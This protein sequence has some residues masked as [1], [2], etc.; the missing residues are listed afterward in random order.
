FR[1]IEE[2]D[3]IMARLKPYP[4]YRDSGVEWIGE[5]PKDWQLIKLRYLVTNRNNSRNQENLPYLGLENIESKTGKIISINEDIIEGQ[6]IRFENK[7]VLFGKLRPY[8]A[9]VAHVDFE[10]HCS[11]EFI[12]LKA[13]KIKAELL[14]YIML[15][16]KFISHVDSS[17]YGTKM[18]RANWEF[19]KNIFIPLS[20]SKQQE[21]IVKFL[22]DRTR[23]IDS[24][25]SDKERLLELLEE[26]RQAIITETVT[27]GLDP[28][29][30]MKDS[31]IEWIGEI[32]EHWET[33]K[34]KFLGDAT[35]GLLYSPTETTYK[36]Q[37]KLVLRASNIQSSM[38][39]IQREDNVYVNKKIP[40]SLLTKVDDILICAR[41]GSRDLIGKS[42]LID[43]HSAGNS[44]GAF[45]TVF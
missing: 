24:L 8:L 16:S 31:G 13:E 7:D 9:K 45:T 12:V 28:H 21:E 18:P 35:M 26:K 6:S 27:K 36:E 33:V 2:G 34:L 15:S 40:E 42:A 23:Q 43:E 1:E 30:K 22:N 4:E 29:V 3:G 5:I 11:T 10:G 25:I 14:K 41:S 39:D 17:T 20:I 19:I 37:G 38:I 44:F 32:P